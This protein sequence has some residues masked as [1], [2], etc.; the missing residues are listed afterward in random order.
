MITVIFGAVTLTHVQSITRSVTQSTDNIVTTAG[1]GELERT[2]EVQGYEVFT[3]ADKNALIQQAEAFEASILG[4]GAA[5]LNY[6]DGVG[7][8][9]ARATDVSWQTWVGRSVI[10]YTITF[11]T[12]NENF[13]SNAETFILSDAHPVNPPTILTLDPQP[14]IRT[15]TVRQGEYTVGALTSQAI[16]PKNSRISVS[17]RFKGTKAEVNTS[18]DSLRTILSYQ[19]PTDVGGATLDSVVTSKVQVQGGHGMVYEAIVEGYDISEPEEIDLLASV[20]YTI[21][22]LRIPDYTLDDFNFQTSGLNLVF[23]SGV[24]TRPL[25]LNNVSSNDHDVVTEVENSVYRITDETQNI[26]GKAYFTSI[27][28]AESFI[29]NYIEPLRATVKI[30]TA[31]GKVGSPA[32]LISSTG[33]PLVLSSI[34]AREPRRDGLFAYADGDLDPNDPG[35]A[36]TLLIDPTQDG[37]RRIS[38]D[39]SMQLKLFRD[40]NAS[41]IA[42]VESDLGIFWDIISSMSFSASVNEFNVETSRSVSITGRTT[43]VPTVAIGS[44]VQLSTAS[45]NAFDGIPVVG[46]NYYITSLAYNAAVPE[47][48]PDSVVITQVGKPIDDE[49]TATPTQT[50]GVQPDKQFEVSVTARTLDSYATAATLV[51]AM[52][53]SSVPTTT[54]PS[55]GAPTPLITNIA[56]VGGPVFPVTNLDTYDLTKLSNVTSHSRSIATKYAVNPST[57]YAV[58]TATVGKYAGSSFVVT[59]MTESI[60][61][62]IYLPDPP[63]GQSYDG[64]FAVGAAVQLHAFFKRILDLLAYAADTDTGAS[65]TPLDGLGKLIID[66]ISLGG[67]EAFTYHGPNTAP[68]SSWTKGERHFRISLSLSGTTTYDISASDSSQQDTDITNESISIQQES[69]KFTQVPISNFGTVFK[70]TGIEPLEEVATRTK[71]YATVVSY[72]GQTLADFK[73]GPST[74]TA[75]DSVFVNLTNSANYQVTDENEYED[76]AGLRR[77]ITAT[78][79]AIKPQDEFV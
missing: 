71:V 27:L 1:V 23:S 74:S 33:N 8:F 11:Q 40:R 61:G 41:A 43:G 22:L 36:T 26:S 68:P 2:V 47:K 76:S 31:P 12:Y 45:E 77:E 3:T 67:V 54:T 75:L 14:A 44:A 5:T 6:M 52:L 24:S 19:N 32:V 17:G 10:K 21:R 60:S 4:E 39:V 69:V 70:A 29:S 57:T 58:N 25:R 63:L 48:V 20:T 51:S 62:Y 72:E 78:R 15:A 46:H 56:G 73:G 59:S 28:D 79:S 50:A 9:Q 65:F 34:K 13:W 16:P 42:S 38:V 64:D 18:L 55:P 53:E 35:G 37:A 7:N 30:P 49:G 66:N